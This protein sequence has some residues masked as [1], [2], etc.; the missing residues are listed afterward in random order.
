MDVNLASSKGD[1]N[2]KLFSENS[3]SF[4]LVVIE[5]KG[6][7]AEHKEAASARRMDRK[8]AGKRENVSHVNVFLKGIR[9]NF[10]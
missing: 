10:F 1:R 6:E 2:I 7:E 3:N 4:E 8:M 5:R 9:S